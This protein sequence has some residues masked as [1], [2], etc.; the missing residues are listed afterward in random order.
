MDELK[1]T[2]GPWSF[3]CDKCATVMSANHPIADITKGAWGDDYP[4]LRPMGSELLGQYEVYMAQ[5]TYG[6]VS[7]DEAIANALLIAAAPELYKALEHANALLRVL[8]PKDISVRETLAD[9][10]A[11]LSRARGE[12]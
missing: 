7:P 6:D 1:A 5:I 10:D 3:C 9:N 4:S 12:S 8:V 2:P 11:L